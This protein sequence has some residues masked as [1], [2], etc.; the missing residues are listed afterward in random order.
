MLQP[1]VPLVC[2][3]N[4]T[5]AYS[6]YLPP[7]STYDKPPDAVMEVPPNLVG[8]VIG[9]AGV[10]INDIKDRTGAHVRVHVFRFLRRL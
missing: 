10:R 7:G 1:T 5:P 3:Q 4:K 2:A 6:T 9:K 8:W